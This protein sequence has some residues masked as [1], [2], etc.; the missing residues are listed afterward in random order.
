L[1][2]DAIERTRAAAQR[3]SWAEASPDKASLVAEDNELVAGC[4]WWLC[5]SDEAIT[6]RLSAE[7]IVGQHPRAVYN[8]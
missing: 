4:E 2:A 5:H 8:A 6:T 1:A 3:R 7:H